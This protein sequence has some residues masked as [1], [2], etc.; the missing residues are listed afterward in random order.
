MSSTTKLNFSNYK[1]AAVISSVVAVVIIL[2]SVYVGKN[3]FF[4]MLNGNLGKIADH[5]FEYFTHLGDAL[6]WIGWLIWILFK[7]QKPIVPL[8]VASFIFDTLITQVFKQVIFPYQNRPSTA[9]TD[10][11]FIHFV[12]GVTVHSINSFPSGHTATAFTFMLLITLSTKS[13]FFMLL[14]LIV[15]MVVGYSRI[16]LGQHFP[17]DVGG[18]IVVAV[19]AVSCA[20]PL[21]RWFEKRWLLKEKQ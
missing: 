12:E 9:I 19:I 8:I 16:Y 3:K 13:R 10:G 20:I 18:G 21:Q 15:A 4:L 2:L 1:I 11:S 17:L 14:S 6:L 5:F 7:K